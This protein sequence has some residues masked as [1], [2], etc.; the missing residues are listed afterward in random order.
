MG[1]VGSQSINIALKAARANIR[2]NL[3]SF[4]IHLLHPEN[5]QRW[6]GE[7]RDRG[8]NLPLVHSSAELGRDLYK[9]IFACRRSA[10]IVS[11]VRLPLDRAISSFFHMLNFH[12]HRQD[13][14]FAK[15]NVSLDELHEAFYYAQEYIFPYTLNWFEEEFQ[16][17]TGIDI[18]Q[19][20][21]DREA[22]SI[23]VSQGPY[24][25]LLMRTELE[26]PCKEVLMRDFLELPDFQFV[27]QRNISIR[28]FGEIYQEFKQNVS[29]RDEYIQQMMAS[30]FVSHF[31]SQ[32]EIDS[33]LQKYSIR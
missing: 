32:S 33:M 12:L 14:E 4:H 21:F 6:T 25:L 10:R 26:N 20:P 15:A 11:L 9:H 2:R 3:K 17:V 30:Q 27:G 28:K 31:F 24:D 16:P 1:K 19:H 8:L 5:I 7:Y 22:G 18:Y 13:F 23:T 29:F